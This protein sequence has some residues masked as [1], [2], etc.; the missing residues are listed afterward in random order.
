[1][2]ASP[3]LNLATAEDW[4]R[5]VG[6]DQMLGASEWERALT[7][8]MLWVANHAPM[9]VGPGEMGTIYMLNWAETG[10]TWTFY[11]QATSAA[12]RLALVEAF[13]DAAGG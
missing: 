2:N 4:L 9:E 8:D 1:M 3:G 13:I 12:G 11:I 6:S 7:G 5:Y 10:G